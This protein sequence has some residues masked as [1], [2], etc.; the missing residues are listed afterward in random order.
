MKALGD[1]IHSK[2]L[3]FGIYQ[4]PREETCAQYFNAIGGA[5]GA[6]NHE[7]QDADTFAS[8]GVDFLKY[9]WCSPEGTIDDQ[10]R[11]FAIMRD[12]LAA[13]GRSLSDVR[14]V[15]L[16][17][18]HDDHIGFAERARQAGIPAHIHEAAAGENGATPLQ[19]S[20]K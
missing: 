5:T 20:L 17:H 18:A 12:A 13:M 11:R 14:A 19:V 9:D 1:Y 15:L 16:T 4:A 8:W 2:G 7:Q 10:V 6:L 3:K